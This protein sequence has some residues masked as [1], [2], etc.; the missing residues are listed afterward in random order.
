MISV[1]DLDLIQ[2]SE[3]V[4]LGAVSVQSTAAPAGTT[5]VRLCATGT[6]HVRFDSVNP[7][8][9]AVSLLI[10]ANAAGMVF[11]MPATYKVAVIQDGA[12]T[13]NCNI[14][15]LRR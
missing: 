1:Q 3:N 9:T 4:A 2:E 14:A 15:F 10:P 8:A 12:A 6:C 11:R 5:H 7:T 13:G